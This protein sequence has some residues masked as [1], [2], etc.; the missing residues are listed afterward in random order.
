MSGSNSHFKIATRQKADLLFSA[1]ATPVAASDIAVW[2]VRKVLGY[3]RVSILAMGAQPFTILIE[4]A[5]S[6]IGPFVQTA[7]LP[8]SVDTAT[9][10]EKVCDLIVPCG[11]YM[12]ASLQNDGIQSIF[13]G[14]I[15]GLPQ[16]GSSGD[17][18]VVS[19][20]G[21]YIFTS[22]GDLTT[23]D[24]DLI[25][26]LPGLGRIVDTL[27]ALV[28]TAPIGADAIME[29]FRGDLATGVLG[30]SLGTVSVPD[31]SKFAQTT[32]VPTRIRT[33]EFVA[34]FIN[35]IGSITPGANLTGA[36]M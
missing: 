12:R 8:S 3:G 24:N 10:L 25:P 31:G 14:K 11:L 33:D 20:P 7:A 26:Y 5:T 1:P 17:A 23:T 22:P 34:M 21:T 2:G 29:F 30:A 19:G 6:P 15:I 16:A 13:Q 4:E 28:K 27:K 18:G 32:I 36:V 35:Q 9:G